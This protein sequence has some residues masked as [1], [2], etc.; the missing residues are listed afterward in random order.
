MKSPLILSPQALLRYQVVSQV[1]AR[2]L[3]GKPLAAAIGEVLALPQVDVHGRPVSL[4]ERTL[5][6]WSAAYRGGGVAALEPKARPR[7][8]ASARPAVTSLRSS[9]SEVAPSW[10]SH[11]AADLSDGAGR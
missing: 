1:E 9:T 5:Y 8:E 3:A 2:V 10:S 6:R 11:L 4:S 7:V